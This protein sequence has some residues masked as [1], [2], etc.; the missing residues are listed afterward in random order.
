MSWASDGLPDDVLAPGV[1]YGYDEAE[2]HRRPNLSYSGAKVML[3]CPAE[4]RYQR[5][6]PREPSRSMVMGTCVHADI[7]EGRVI[8]REAVHKLGTKAG[9]AEAAAIAADGLIRLTRAESVAVTGMVTALREHD[10][11]RRLLKVGEPEVSL[12]WVDEETGVPLRGRLDWLRP[13]WR[14][15]LKTT[16]SANPDDIRRDIRAYRYDI[17]RVA[18]DEGAIACDLD[19]PR[20]VFVFVANCPPHIVTLVNLGEDWLPGAYHDWHHAIRTYAACVETGR[21]PGYA[22]DIITIDP[23]RWHTR[24]ETYA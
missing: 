2:Y 5:D 11:V 3:D 15:D 6:Y 10:G 22:D 23:P 1:H 14:L 24:Q 12:S 17:Q 18:Y 16:S 13:G 4:Y 7:L 19:A 20:M 9:D 21:W 8:W